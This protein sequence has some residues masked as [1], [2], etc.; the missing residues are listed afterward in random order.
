[1]GAV[2]RPNINICVGIKD[3]YVGKSSHL[4]EKIVYVAGKKFEMICLH[5]LI[6]GDADIMRL[7]P[8]SYLGSCQANKYT[9]YTSHRRF[10]KFAI[11]SVLLK[12]N[13]IMI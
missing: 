10:K 9:A 13:V 7:T 2:G 12:A 5:V 4:A 6:S 1:M 8:R 11:V 3:V